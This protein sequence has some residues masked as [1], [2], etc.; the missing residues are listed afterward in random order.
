ME[1]LGERD[2]RIALYLTDHLRTL[3][4]PA[5]TEGLS[6]HHSR[7]LAALHTS[8]ASFFG[9][10]HDAAGGGFPQ[11]TVDA[12]WDLVWKG[13][14]TNDT[15]HP[16]RAFIASPERSRREARA[17]RFR[18]RRLVPPSAEGRWAAVPTTERASATA[19]AAALTQQLLTRH[20]VVARDV[21]T[22]R[23]GGRRLQHDLPGAAAARGHRAGAAR[24][25]RGRPG[26]RA[27][28]RARAPSICCAPNAT[29]RRRPPP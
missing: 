25:L 28:R 5:S 12:L 4:G 13:L 15:L 22:H 10:L 3:A 14:V 2:G 18:S 26:R 16:L 17:D 23:A 24:L 1:P 27:V 8:G 19:W 20:G 7:L 6:E 11:E 21:T 29:R 9:P